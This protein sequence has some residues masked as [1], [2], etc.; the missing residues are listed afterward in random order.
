MATAPTL[1]KAASEDS[2]LTAGPDADPYG[3]DNSSTSTYTSGADGGSLARRAKAFGLE[4]RAVEAYDQGGAKDESAAKKRWRHAISKIEDDYEHY[5]KARSFV[6]GAGLGASSA[7]LVMSIAI[8]Y[9]AY[10]PSSGAIHE[11]VGG[12]FYSTFRAAFLLSFW[13]L[14]M[15]LMQFLWRRANVPY[16][17]H[18]T[19]LGQVNYAGTLV[20]AFSS[21]ILVF[22]FFIA[23][24]LQLLA[25]AMFANVIPKRLLP[26][27][28]LL[29]PGILLLWPTDRPP[30]F[31]FRTAGSYGQRW[32]LVREFFHATVGCFFAEP[33]FLRTLLADVLCS[34]PKLLTDLQYSLC[35]YT[36]SPSLDLD[37][38]AA[39]AVE[40][41][42]TTGGSSSYAA[43]AA[44]LS[45]LP[46]FIRLVQSTKKALQ[47]LRDSGAARRAARR[48]GRSG[49]EEDRAGRAGQEAAIRNAMNSLKYMASL[50]LLAVS[51]ID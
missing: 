50:A 38:A 36:S 21:L 33:S 42:C 27:L 6:L 30:L 28:A 20:L 24:V 16:H 34:M 43:V 22:Y 26:L 15:G 41:S 8:M 2:P 9:V 32:R 14:L 47:G 29:S 11:L 37:G 1:E 39:A 17:A 35:V 45:V 25:P 12:G 19:A 3:A 18:M 40:V 23:F 49:E 31:F 10:D 44:L 51:L 48:R 13:S 4:R 46:F 7:L 5:V